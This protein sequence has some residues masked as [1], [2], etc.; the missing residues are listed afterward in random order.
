MITGIGLIGPT[1][2][3]LQAFWDSLLEGRSGIGRITR[4]DPD[5]YS[6][7]IGGE[8]RDRSYEELLEPRKLRTTTHVT[9]LALA[10]AELALRDARITLG[11]NTSRSVSE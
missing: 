6:C 3:G 5:S 11:G 7:Q 1:G 8:V 9:Q 2:V 10:A 4:F